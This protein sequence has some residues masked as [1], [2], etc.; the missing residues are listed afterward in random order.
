MNKFVQKPSQILFCRGFGSWLRHKRDS[1]E[2]ECEQGSQVMEAVER[3]HQVWFAE[4]PPFLVLRALHTVRT[5]CVREENHQFLRKDEG[6]EEGGKCE[7]TL[8]LSQVKEVFVQGSQGLELLF[9][10]EGRWVLGFWLLFT[11]GEEGEE[12]N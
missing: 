4:G 12:E 1:G 8:R 2:H 7:E 9:R 5:H 3:F 11:S 10:R 6:Q